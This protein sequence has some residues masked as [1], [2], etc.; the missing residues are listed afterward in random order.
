VYHSSQKRAERGQGPT[1]RQT[2]N[3]EE[4]DM[5]VD[6]DKDKESELEETWRYI[7]RKTR[8]KRGDMPRDRQ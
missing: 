1:G 2:R 3:R 8:D 7:R 6:K 4:I 5:C